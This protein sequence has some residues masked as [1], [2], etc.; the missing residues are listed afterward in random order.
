MSK[1]TTTKSYGVKE[2]RP[3]ASDFLIGAYLVCSFIAFLFG[4]MYASSSYR[5][6]KCYPNKPIEMIFP[7]FGIGCFMFKSWESEE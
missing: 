7:A 6:V 4:G 3:N 5:S 1:K 2:C